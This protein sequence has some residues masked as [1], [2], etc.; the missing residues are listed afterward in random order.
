[1]IAIDEP[2]I[3]DVH[4]VVEEVWT[5]FLGS[6]EPIQIGAST[7]TT[8]LVDRLML[9][10][11]TWT[12]AI[13]VTGAWEAMI[14]ISVPVPAA[15][16]ITVGMLGLDPAEAETCGLEDLTDALGELVNIVGGGVKSLMPGPSAL[17][18]PL[19][20]QGAI[21]STSN[22]EEVCAVDLTWHG[23]P[24]RVSI[25]VPRTTHGIGG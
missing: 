2:T 7:E 1:M 11:D 20:A 8:S 18:L 15:G 13:T 25:D 12:A 6:D 24:I 16:L 19:V 3:S 5:S 23:H 22:L 9:D 4:A 21:T 14:L 10:D 17:S